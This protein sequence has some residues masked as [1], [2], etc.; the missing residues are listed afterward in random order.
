MRPT[1]RHRGGVPPLGRR[2]DRL[3]RRPR[4]TAL[5]Q[6]LVDAGADIVVGSPRPSPAQGGGR[7]GTAFVDYGLG[8]FVFYN[9]RA[10]TG[11]PACSC[12]TATGSDIDTYQ[13]VPARIRGGVPAAVPGRRR[14]RRRASPHWN[15]LTGVHRPVAVISPGTL[16]A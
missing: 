12:V 5:A 11:A 3:A 16:S 1:V 6:R 10:S 9:E 14:V 13:W 15:E 7:L 8:N 4:Q 2:A